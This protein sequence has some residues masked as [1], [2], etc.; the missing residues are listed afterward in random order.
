MALPSVAPFGNPAS[1][2]HLLWPHVGPLVHTP[3]DL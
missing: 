3:F 2:Q 1:F